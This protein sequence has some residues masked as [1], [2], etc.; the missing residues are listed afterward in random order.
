MY[1]AET[2]SSSRWRGAAA[3]AIG[4]VIASAAMVAFNHFLGSTGFGSD[5]LGEHHHRRRIDAKPN[6]SDGTIAD[7]PASRQAASAAAESVAGR[8]LDEREKDAAGPVF[9]YGFGAVAGAIYG[10]LAARAPQVTAGGG[11][12][13]GAAVF[14]TATEL[15]LPL[16]GLARRPTEYPP[17]RHVASLATHLVYGVTLEAVR[18]RLMRRTRARAAYDI[19]ALGV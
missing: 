10:A 14:L 12:P 15:A 11:A 5:D 4:G 18:R 8:P 17:A 9:H 19:T 6:D 13:Y 16:A 2:A 1:T 7:E 3:G